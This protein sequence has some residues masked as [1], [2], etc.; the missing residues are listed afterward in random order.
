MLETPG[1]LWDKSRIAQRTASEAPP[2]SQKALKKK[3][4]NLAMNGSTSFAF[5][6]NKLAGYPSKGNLQGLALP[7]TK[8][9]VKPC[10]LNS[11]LKNIVRRRLKSA[12]AIRPQPILKKLPVRS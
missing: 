4:R 10:G 7:A 12:V 8:P 9:H 5:T 2:K 11:S 3:A 1:P 6:Y